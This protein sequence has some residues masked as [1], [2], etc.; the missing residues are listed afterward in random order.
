MTI[1][2]MGGILCVSKAVYID[3]DGV[4]YEDEAPPC[5]DRCRQ[6]LVRLRI[7]ARRFW[8]PYTIVITIIPIITIITIT[9]III[10]SITIITS[11]ITSR[12]VPRSMWFRGRVGL[13]RCQSYF[14]F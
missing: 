7:S 5:V 6:P 11:T 4:L 1:L 14:S 9:I 2:K 3:A 13:A 8:S 10:T 12:A